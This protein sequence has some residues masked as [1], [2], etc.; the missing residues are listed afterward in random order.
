VPWGK[1]IG[2]ATNRAPAM[3]RFIRDRAVAVIGQSN[4]VG[5]N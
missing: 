4:G 5:T 3:I 2:L 1:I